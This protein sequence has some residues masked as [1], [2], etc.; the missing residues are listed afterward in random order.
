MKF[1]RSNTLFQKSLASAK[2]A[3]ELYNKPVFPYRNESFSILMINAWELLLK[4]KKL[5]ANKNKMASIYV[6]EKAKNKSGAASKKERYKKNRTGNFLTQSIVDLLKSEITDHN[7]Q[8]HLHI[9]LEVRDN[10]VH[11]MNPSKLLSKHYLD[12]VTASIKAYQTLAQKWFKYSFEDEDMLVIPVGFNLPEEYDLNDVNTKEEKNLLK[13]I[14]EQRNKAQET[15]EFDIALNVD[16]R[17]TRSK[18]SSATLVK[19]DPTGLPI[20]IDSEEVFKNKYPLDFEALKKQLSARYSDFKQNNQFWNAK[21]ELERDSVYAGVRYLNYEAQK[22][23]KKTYY[24]SEIFK[25]FDTIYQKK[26]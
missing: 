22:G 12:I 2:A 11:Y 18:D 10:S 20:K 6:K 17:F 25:K 5:K 16:V 1:S 26:V 8:I 19:Y 15:S 23:S 14:S 24:S 9:L 7:L 3:I 13:Y 4:A 21:R